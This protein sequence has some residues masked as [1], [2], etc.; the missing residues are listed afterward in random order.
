MTELQWKVEARMRA[1]YS[2]ELRRDGW[3]E[4]DKGLWCHPVLGIHTICDAP[5]IQHIADIR[6]GRRAIWCF[7]IVL[8]LVY[9]IITFINWN[10]VC[11]L[12]SI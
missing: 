1:E 3:D 2:S 7:L 11:E 4:T 8:T 5:R 6:Y 9:G 12:L 10:H